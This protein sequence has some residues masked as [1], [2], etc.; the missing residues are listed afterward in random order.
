[1]KILL[2]SKMLNDFGIDWF[3][4]IEAQSC[5]W[6]CLVVALVSYG[7][8]VVFAEELPIVALAG[9]VVSALT[10]MVYAQLDGD[11][12]WFIDW[13]NSHWFWWFLCV[14][15]AVVFITSAFQTFWAHICMIKYLFTCPV[16]A[17]LGLVLGILWFAAA[18]SLVGAFMVNHT[19]V[20]VLIILCSIGSLTDGAH[21]PAIYVSGEGHITGHGY[22][23]GSKFHGDNGG[24]YHY[25]GNKWL[26]D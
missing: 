11:P 4:G 7:V 10:V 17:L 8:Y 15:I 9:N 21:V 6:L 25:D 23:G 20:S 19:F 12:F 2:Y 3:N 1:M 22:D 13:E 5:F 16:N 18:M 24:N 26:R 14:I